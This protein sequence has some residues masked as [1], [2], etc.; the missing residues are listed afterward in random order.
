[1]KP[2]LLGA[3]EIEIGASPTPKSDNSTNWPD[4]NW[5]ASRTSSSMMRSSKSFSLSVRSMIEVI[6]A[7]QGRYGLAAS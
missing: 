2:C 4:A 7:G 3:E 5:N 1:M 6:R